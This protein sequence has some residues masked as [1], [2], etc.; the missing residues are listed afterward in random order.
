MCTHDVDDMHAHDREVGDKR[1]RPKCSL[2]FTQQGEAPTCGDGRDA[3]CCDKDGS[4][5]DGDDD[6]CCKIEDGPRNGS[7]NT[8]GDGKKQ[9]PQQQQLQEETITASIF[10]TGEVKVQTLTLRFRQT[11]GGTGKRLAK[12]NNSLFMLE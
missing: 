2:H 1:S 4:C 7:S 5:L 11:G 9:V 3:L 10:S 6:W 8:I 12:G